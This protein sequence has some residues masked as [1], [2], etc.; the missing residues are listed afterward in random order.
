M[1]EAFSSEQEEAEEELLVEAEE[2]QVRPLERP[3][4]EECCKMPS[5]R[6]C[7]L[8]DPEFSVAVNFYRNVRGI[9][10]CK[11]PLCIGCKL[12]ENQGT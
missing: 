3:A 11:S 4:V 7:K 10:A 1:E 5:S 9:R 8:S 6:S 2:E 12:E